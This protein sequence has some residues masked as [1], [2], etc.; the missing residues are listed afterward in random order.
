M[1]VVFI[2]RKP[3]IEFFHPIWNSGKRSRD[4]ERA[5]KKADGV[6]EW[7]VRGEWGVKG[8]CRVSECQSE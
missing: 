4:D 8:G 3:F 2:P 1:D 7:G 6:D 5:C